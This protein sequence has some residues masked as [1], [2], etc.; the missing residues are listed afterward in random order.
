MT[1]T[2]KEQK[3]IDYIFSLPDLESLRGDPEKILKVIDDYDE[4]FMDIGPQKGKM[5]INKM[6]EANIDIMIEL[7]GYYGYSA[8]LFGK[9]VAKSKGKYYSFELSEEYASM[10]RKLVDLAGLSDTV[11]IKVGPSGSSLINFASELNDAGTSSLDFVF[12][13]HDKDLYDTDLRLMESLSL[14]SPGT[15]IVADNLPSAPLY[16]QYLDFTPQERRTYNSKHKSIYGN[17]YSGRWNIL[18]E[19]KTILTKSH[20]HGHD[21]GIEFTDCIQ[22]LSS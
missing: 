8:L 20:G 6:K 14:I 10:S 13:D 19:T 11:T 9:E 15:V 5:V 12:I 17:E 16:K 21:D 2:T 18:Y 7:G 1:S 3:L 22:Y 4:W